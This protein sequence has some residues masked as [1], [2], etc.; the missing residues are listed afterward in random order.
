MGELIV[1][2]VV[3]VGHR[4]WAV[5]LLELLKAVLLRCLDLPHGSAWL[6]CLKARRLVVRRC[7]DAII[8]SLIDEA[9][10]LLL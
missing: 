5:V 6:V 3:F 2:V 1:G 9:D 8:L 7:D 10:S 4:R